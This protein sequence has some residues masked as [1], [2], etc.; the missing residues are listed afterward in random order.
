MALEEREVAAF[1]QAGLSYTLSLQGSA[2][3][4]ADLLAGNSFLKDGCLPWG[5]VTAGEEE[6][7]CPVPSGKEFDADFVHAIACKPMELFPGKE[8]ESAS[9]AGEELSSH[10]EIGKVNCRLYAFLEEKGNWCVQLS[11]PQV[12]QVMTQVCVAT[13]LSFRGGELT[14]W[15]E[16]GGSLALD[17]LA[18]RFRGKLEEQ[19]TKYEFRLQKGERVGGEGKSTKEEGQRG[20]EKET[21]EGRQGEKEEGTKEG[22]QEGKEEEREVFAYKATLPLE[23]KSLRELYWEPIAFF[24]DEEGREYPLFL[25]MRY[26]YRAYLTYLYR[27]CYRQGKNFFYPYATGFHKLAFAFRE[28]NPYDGLF[29]HGKE[30][31]SIL[32]FRLLRPYFKKNPC[33]LVYEKYC[34]SAQENA[35]FFFRYCMEQEGKGKV[36]QEGIEKREV[37]GK[38]EQGGAEKRE[39][40]GKIEQDGVEKREGEGKVKQ[41]GEEKQALPRTRVFYVLQKASKDWKRVAPYKRQVLVYGSLRHLLAMQAAKL[42]V[43]TDTRYQ[44]YPARMRGSFLQRILR[45]K[46]VVFLQHGLT[47]L[48]RVD[49]YYGK[50]EAGGC[51]LFITTCEK[52]RSIVAEN[53][54]YEEKEIAVTGFARWD[55]L[56]D[57]AKARKKRE[58][59]I[60]PTWRSWLEHL[61]PEDFLQTDYY[62][63]YMQLLNSPRLI[64]LLEENDLT[65]CFYLHQKFRDYLSDFASSS[66]RLRLIPFGEVPANEL[67]MECSLLVTDYSS[68]CWDVFYLGKP[69]LFFQFDRPTYLEVHGSYLDMEKDLIGDCAFTVE[70][71]MEGLYK[72]VNHHF[73]LEPRYKALREEYFPVRDQDNCKRIYEAIGKRWPGL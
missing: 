18:L 55:A 70:E 4:N 14:L 21:K 52:E 65:A 69:T 29:F 67:L 72:A 51:D 41:E 37:E 20:K 66:S 48:K 15:A 54:G 44:V 46:P 9:K 71:L 64:Q 1:C 43:T 57:K 56:E 36:E 47:A 61:S 3:R 31:L 26:R 16:L 11:P 5:Y 45:K 62:K 34:M 7:C 25:T 30:A 35:F 6:F 39:V 33:C 28:K 10:E 24:T 32:L 17:S 42:L 40:E 58:I 23:G 12:Y 19:L 38:T 53:F 2:L 59:L 49:F 68:V 8:E 50:G 73:A 22:R 13:S 60:M 63:S 27:G